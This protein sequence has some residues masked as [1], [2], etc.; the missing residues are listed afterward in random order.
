[1]TDPIILH[2]IDT[3]TQRKVFTNMLE[4][5]GQGLYITGNQSYKDETKDENVGN[6]L[7]I[8]YKFLDDHNYTYNPDKYYVE[9]HSYCAIGGKVEVPFAWHQDNYGAWDEKVIS[10]LYYLDK[11]STIEGGNLLYTDNKTDPDSI[12]S[13]CK[14]KKVDI[15]KIETES[16]MLVMFNGDLWHKPEDVDGYG[17]RSLLIVQVAI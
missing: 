4:T 5:C 12:T 13:V 16:N 2:D 10:V 3:T 17:I 8:T 1:M 6:L 15:K 9:L 11:D 7:N 14:R